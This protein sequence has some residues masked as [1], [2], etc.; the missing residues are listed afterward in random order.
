MR[1]WED[2]A[3]AL[4]G[5]PLLEGARCKAKPERFDLDV[6]SGREAIDWAV[7]TCGGC[8][9]LRK[10]RA[11]VD[12]LD[13]GRLPSGVVAGCLVDPAAYQTARAVM[14]A[15]RTPPPR[16]MTQPRQGRLRRRLQAVVEAAGP[17]G[18]TV[19]EAAAQL[20]G[21]PLTTARIELTRQG[22]ER[23]VGRGLL[24]RVDRGRAGGR[25]RAA[26]Y[27]AVDRGAVAS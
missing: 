6:R 21:T 15:E 5:I 13:P 12:S 19:A 11:W 27:V 3:G 1:A 8:P 22:L 4:A 9:A 10:C 16:P 24:R 23:S 26:R 17:R 2:L 25:G 20:H 7:F 18:L 14:A